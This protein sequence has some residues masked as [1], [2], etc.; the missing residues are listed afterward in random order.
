MRLILFTVTASVAVGLILG[1]GLRGFPL[2]RPR[3]TALAF[4]AVAAQLLPIV[5]LAGSILLFASFAALIAFA[6]VNLRVPGFAPV[7]IGL[8][9]NALVIVANQ[10]MPVTRDALVASN[11]SATLTALVTDGGSKHHLADDDTRLVFLADAI[12][13]GAPID[14][15]ISVGDILVHVGV[16]WFVIAAMP[17][18]RR[19][20]WTRSVA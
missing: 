6:A 4:A 17:K 10:G 20:A 16:G 5:G 13:V 19:A 12:A 15:A 11:Q 3:W 8:A 7:L 1:H 9:L 2:V 14:Q 18:R